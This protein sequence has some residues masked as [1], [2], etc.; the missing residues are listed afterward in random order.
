MAPGGLNDGT[1]GF[2]RRR[3]WF[4]PMKPDRPSDVSLNCFAH[5][6]NKGSIP[7]ARPRDRHTQSTVSR[8]GRINSDS[9]LKQI[10]CKE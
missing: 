4:W 5:A 3:L 1:C 8:N 6:S 2:E 10:N 7:Q 9:F